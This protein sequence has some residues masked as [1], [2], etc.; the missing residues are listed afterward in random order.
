MQ[1][2]LNVIH[3]NLDKMYSIADLAKAS[4]SSSASIHRMFLQYCN[5]TPLSYMTRYR[6]MFAE[7]MLSTGERSIKEIAS[8]LGYRNQLY[9]SSVFRKYHGVS[10]SDFRMKKRENQG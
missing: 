4:G 3:C 2:L 1:N 10:P 6:M 8:L 9:F 5:C 7:E